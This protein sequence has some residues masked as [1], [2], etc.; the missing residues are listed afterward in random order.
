V[1][2]V[3]LNVLPSTLKAV[4]WH[5]L[6]RFSTQNFFAFLNC[7]MRAACCAHLS[8]LSWSAIWGLTLARS[9][10][11]AAYVRRRLYRPKT[12]CSTGRPSP[13][14]AG[15][16]LY[17]P[18]QHILL[19]FFCAWALRVGHW[20]LSG[21]GGEVLEL[22]CTGFSSLQLCVLFEVTKNCF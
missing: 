11:A 15:S 3:H 2:Q 10:A 20:V 1:A 19:Q 5:F 21:W 8:S 16:F 6:F 14:T 9:G 13:P 22:L 4:K 18:S 12:R 17:L 7:P